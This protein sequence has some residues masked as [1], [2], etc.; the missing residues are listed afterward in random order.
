MY[1]LFY[2][3]IIKGV[4]V[5]PGYE[6]DRI[7]NYMSDNKL[8]PLS[9]ILTHAHPDHMGAAKPIADTFGLKPFLHAEDFYLL[10]YYSILGRQLGVT[11]PPPENIEKLK[12]GKQIIDNIEV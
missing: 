6:A 5:D 9:I 8:N 2:Y 10:Q 12:E 7:K 1:K 11:E 4:I 3:C